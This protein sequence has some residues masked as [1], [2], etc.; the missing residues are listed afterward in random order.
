[1]KPQSAFDITV[2][3]Y[4]RKW[5][6]FTLR[7]LAGNLGYEKENVLSRLMRY[8]TLIRSKG[9]SSSP[10][11]F[12]D[13]EDIQKVEDALEKLAAYNPTLAKIIL[14][15]YTQK[16][17]KKSLS[18]SHLSYHIYNRCLPTA[19]AWLASYLNYASQP[20]PT[21]SFKYVQSF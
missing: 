3:T 13:D 9:F 2:D 6:T 7:T 5:A 12:S 11:T 15:K 4:L 19:M 17:L 10:L 1:M 18:L 20:P 21:T 14:I 16:D 8:G